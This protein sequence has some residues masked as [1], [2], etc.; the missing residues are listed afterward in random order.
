MKKSDTNEPK[1]NPDTNEVAIIPDVK[2]ALNK[3][4]ENGFLRF[5]VLARL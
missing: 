3:L 1:W 5:P 2:I 4:K